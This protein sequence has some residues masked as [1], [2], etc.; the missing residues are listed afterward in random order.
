MGTSLYRKFQ[1]SESNYSA[2]NILFLNL[3]LICYQNVNLVDNK[4]NNNN[5]ILYT[6]IN[7]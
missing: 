1:V 5:N 7:M 2:V 3:F 6:F 4:D